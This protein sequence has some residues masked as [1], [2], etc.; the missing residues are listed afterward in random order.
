M[1]KRQ[2][3]RRGRLA[4]GPII[5]ISDF[6]GSITIPYHKPSGPLVYCLDVKVNI[7]INRP[8]I[9][10]WFDCIV[11]PSSKYD[12]R[13][14]HKGNGG[15][16]MLSNILLGMFIQTP[17]TLIKGYDI[18]HCYDI[19]HYHEFLYQLLMVNCNGTISED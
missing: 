16:D 11:K 1:K 4:I 12:I 8:I 3:M 5:T 13:V 19:E 7:G 17:I 10:S 15:H 14:Y 6:Y 9:K 2:I 18:E